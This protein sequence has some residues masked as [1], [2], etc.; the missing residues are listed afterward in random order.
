MRVMHLSTMSVYGSA[1][2]L[3]ILPQRGL[4]HV[5]LDVIGNGGHVERNHIDLCLHHLLLSQLLS[6]ALRRARGH[7]RKRAEEAV[8]LV[9]EAGGEVDGRTVAAVDAVADMQCPQSGDLD[10]LA[11]GVRELDKM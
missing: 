4:G 6:Y 2:G 7:T 8:V 1:E 5:V 11:I 10:G 3:K 9:V